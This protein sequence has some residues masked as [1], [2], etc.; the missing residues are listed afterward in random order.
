MCAVR[1]V[2]RCLW[3]RCD[4]LV[5]LLSRG[6]AQGLDVNGTDNDGATALMLAC[7]LGLVSVDNEP[8]LRQHCCMVVTCA[9]CCQTV[10]VDRLLDLGARVDVV[11]IDG[12]SALHYAYAFN[13]VRS[14]A[15]VRLLCRAS[16]GR[17]L[18]ARDMRW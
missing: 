6:P 2:L 12:N 9:R 8:R 13:Q 3:R 18:A 16:C 5:R 11:D 4:L 14:Q 7:R 15:C 1:G 17:P 10:V